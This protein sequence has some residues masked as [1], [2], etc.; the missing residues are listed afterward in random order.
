MLG[1]VLLV[2]GVFALGVL[3]GMKIRFSVNLNLDINITEG[4]DDDEDF[5]D[6]LS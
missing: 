6:V 5:R 1:S 4:G 2:I 3:I